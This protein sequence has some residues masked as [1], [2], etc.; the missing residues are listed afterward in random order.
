MK[1]IT[2]SLV[3]PSLLVGTTVTTMGQD[4]G[5]L[6]GLVFGDFYQVFGH[7]DPAIEDLNGFWFRRLYLTYDRSVAEKF[8]A[9]VRFEANSPGDF[10]TSGVLDPFIKDLYVAYVDKAYEV[11]LGLQPTPTYT[12]IEDFHGYRYIE[13]TPLDLY[14]ITDSRDSGLSF[15]GKSGDGKTE[16]FL[17]I[18]NDSGTKSETNKGKAFYVRL[19][20]WF[21]QNFYVEGTADFRDKPAGEEWT[22]L[23]GFL[24]YK[25]H[26][27]N[28]GVIF[29][30]QKRN[31]TSTGDVDLDLWSF[32]VGVQATDTVKPFFRVDFLSD[33]V[34]GASGISYLAIDDTA[35]P[36]LYI[37]GVEFKLAE[38]VY[39]T[40]NVEFVTYRDAAGPDPDDIVIGRLTYF[41]KF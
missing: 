41:A 4:Q 14:K 16:Y 25:Q 13:K 15:R 24:G 29:G 3:V 36:T 22:T 40:P 10:S 12:N 9:R 28:A 27:V 5:K 18:G 37:I 21:N 6:S 8:K 33:P 17:M 38:G 26:K 23:S 30:S 1:T 35:T 32:Y 19:G 2:L 34:P 11:T 20:H 7:S 39:I 31:D